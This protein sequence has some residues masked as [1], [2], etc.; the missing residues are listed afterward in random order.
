[1][2][3]LAILWDSLLEAIDA[4]VFYVM[5]GLSLLTIVLVASISYHPAD[6]QD[7]MDYLVNNLNAQSDFLALRQGIPK[8][9]LRCSLEDFEAKKDGALVARGERSEPW[10]YDYSYVLAFKWSVPEGED[11]ATGHQ[12]I[13]EAL[14]QS[15]QNAMRA[16]LRQLKN[17]NVEQLKEAEPTEFRFHVTTHGSRVDRR[18]DWPHTLKVLFVVPITRMVKLPLR[19]CINFIEDT[20]VNAWGAAIALLLSCVI[21]AFFIPNMLRKGSIDLL[22]VKP[23]SRITLLVYKYIGGMSFMFLNTVLIVFGI[24]LVLGLRSNMWGVGFLLSIFVLTFEFAI[25]YAVSTLFA[26]LTRSAVVC[27]LMACMTWAILFVVGWGYRIIDATRKINEVV[28]IQQEAMGDDQIENNPKERRRPMEKPLPEWVYTTADIVHFVL[29]RMKDFD[30][31]ITRVIDHDTLPE[32]SPDRKA[33][34][35]LYESFNW[36]EAI[37]VSGLHIALYL[38]IACWRFSVKDY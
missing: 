9:T 12:E 31:L 36:W 6:V 14:K 25:F 37:A 17:V 20:L 5:I 18:E 28:A 21:T 1:M 27:I 23:V 15:L 16:Y 13:G 11:I 24:W 22:L 2:K 30:V 10:N 4:K 33:V 34:D 29:P 35:K 38:G 3:Y 8:G 32:N 19:D 26:V 7:D